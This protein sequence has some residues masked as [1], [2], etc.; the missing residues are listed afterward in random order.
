MALR[1]RRQVQDLGVYDDK[2]KVTWEHITPN[3]WIWVHV[4]CFS[5]KM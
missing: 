1:V 5:M 3:V 2:R 4:C